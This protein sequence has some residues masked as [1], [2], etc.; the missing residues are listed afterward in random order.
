MSKLRTCMGAYLDADTRGR[1]MT[2]AREPAGDAEH[3]PWLREALRHAPDAGAEPPAALSDAILA[4]ARAAHESGAG[5]ARA[6]GDAARGRRSGT[7]SPGLR[8]RPASPA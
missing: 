8:S 3:D 5:R 4:Q 1:T 7:G 6:P 2:D